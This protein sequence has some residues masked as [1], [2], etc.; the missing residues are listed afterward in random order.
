MPEKINIK[1]FFQR[2]L[3]TFTILKLLKEIQESCQKKIFD[4]N[5][6]FCKSDGVWKPQSHKEVKNVFVVCQDLAAW[7]PF[8]WT[9]IQW[10]VG[11]G[12]LQKKA[13]IN[14]SFL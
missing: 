13:R 3:K 7:S 11:N 9:S 5:L 2:I 4:F 12:G 14:Q 1:I 6:N 8:T 10:L